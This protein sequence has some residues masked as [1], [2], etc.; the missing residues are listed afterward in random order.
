MEHIIESKKETDWGLEVVL[1][2]GVIIDNDSILPAIKYYLD[3]CQKINKNKVIVD[4]SK[5]IRNVSIVKF[6]EVAEIIQKEPIRVKIA[7]IPPQLANVSESNA[8]E[9]FSYNRGV[10]L[11]YF[12]DMAA[13]LEWVLQ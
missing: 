5:I 4:A 11:Q 9:T 7:F 3:Q 6:L 13:A 12:Q 8:M 10:K 2:E 1:K